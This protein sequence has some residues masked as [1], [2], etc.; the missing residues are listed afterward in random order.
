MPRG[1][2]D[3]PGMR[4]AAAAIGVEQRLLGLGVAEERD[5]L[6]R[7]RDV[8]AVV[9]ALTSASR[10][11]AR[12]LR[13]VEPRRSPRAQIE[14]RDRR[15][16]GAAH[17]SARSASARARRARDRPR[18][19]SRGSRAPRASKRSTAASPRRSLARAQPDLGRDV[20]D[21][22]EI[23]HQV[24]DG[25]ASPAA[26]SAARRRCRARPDR[27][28]SNRRSGRRSP[29]GRAPAPAGWSGADGRR[30]RPRTGS[31][32]R[33]ARAAWRRPTAAHGGSLRRRASRP[34]RASAPRRCRATCSRCASSAAWVD[35]PAPSPPS[36]VMN[37]RASEPVLASRLRRSDA[38]R[39]TRRSPVSPMPHRRRAAGSPPPPTSSPACSGTSSTTLLAAPD[40]QRADRLA[41]L[42]R[43]QHRAGIDHLAR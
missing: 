37:F 3:Q 11:I 19:A 23:G 31:P 16:I 14:L 25:D 34:A 40:L 13:R 42:D 33:A 8:V 36:K 27:R 28:G 9:A 35:L 24:A 10:T 1:A 5:G 29:T 22:G 30:A 26:R 39:G 12:R 38:R 41:L 2:A 18:A 21:E 4:H 32:R 15:R 7:M 17:R 6:A 43:R 20:E